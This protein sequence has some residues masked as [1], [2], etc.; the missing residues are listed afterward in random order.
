MD[1]STS[2]KELITSTL[3][4]ISVARFE[5]LNIKKSDNYD[6]INSIEKFHLR[7]K[8]MEKLKKM[9]NRNEQIDEIDVQLE[10]LYLCTFKNDVI[11]KK[12]IDN[13]KAIRK[14]LINERNDMK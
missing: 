4:L 2:T 7:K 8:K 13:L 5:W 12:S 10:L 11:V 9:I 14:R 6:K 3:E 1:I